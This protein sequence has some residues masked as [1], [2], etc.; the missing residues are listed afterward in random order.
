MHRNQMECGAAP[1]AAAPIGYIAANTA[2]QLAPG[3]G[4]AVAALG[5]AGEFIPKDGGTRIATASDR[6]RDDGGAL[7]QTKA[8]SRRVRTL[9]SARHGC[10]KFG[11]AARGAEGAEERVP[12]PAPSSRYRKLGPNP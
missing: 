11:E 12:R 2:A 10:G 4:A 1:P 8:G 9:M 7:Y 5:P 3:S 6:R